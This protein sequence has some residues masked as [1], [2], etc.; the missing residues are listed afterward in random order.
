MKVAIIVPIYNEEL[1]IQSFYDRLCGVIDDL[2]AVDF[3]IVYVV[4][5]CA[6]RS[7]DLLKSIAETDH[8]L[9]VIAL[10]KRFGHQKSLL[11]GI[12]Y[13]Y[14]DVD[15]LIMM[16]GD[17]Q[18]PPELIPM[19]INEFSLGN[20]IVHAVRRPS[21]QVGFIRRRAGDFFYYLINKVSDVNIIPNAADYRLIS[22]D[23]AAILINEFRES[24]LF[25]RG[26]FSWIGLNQSIVYFVPDNRS[27]GTSKYDL[28]RNLSFAIAGVVSFSTAPLKIGIYG[29]V[30]TA[31]FAMLLLCY[32]IFDY[33]MGA[34]ALPLGW[35]SLMV[36]LLFF[37]AAQLLS[38]GLI[39]F[40]IGG[41]HN[42][43]RARPNFIVEE[44]F[45]AR[46]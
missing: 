22:R 36:V 19:L 2:K 3:E 27:V 35:S 5:R 7:K 18:H 20:Q 33:Y 46:R 24:E 12:D 44:I 16:D 9:S 21:N 34:Q 42:Q 31:L 4:D 10:S 39:G 37:N 29:G 26:I 13:I 6:D 25:L 28:R 40:Y 41:I 43:T 17:L 14:S 15:A 8:R 38:I 32:T 30:L 45:N 23:V 1:V 11:A